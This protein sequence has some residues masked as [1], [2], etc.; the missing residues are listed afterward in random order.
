[1]SPDILI[2][3]MDFMTQVTLKPK[4]IQDYQR[5]IQ[6]LQKEFQQ[7]QGPQVPQG[8]LDSKVPKA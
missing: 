4:E 3:L 2:K 6:A 1:M 7:S 8:P 5:V